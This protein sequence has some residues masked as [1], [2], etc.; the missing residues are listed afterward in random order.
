MIE[1][2][3]RELKY[4]GT[5][6]WPV[7]AVGDFWDSV[8]DYDCQ[9]ERVPAHKRRFADSLPYLDL[10][11]ENRVLDFCC[12]TGDAEVF[13]SRYRDIGN[14]VMADVSREFLK[15]SNQRVKPLVKNLETW[16]VDTYRLDLPD[17]SFDQVWCFETIEHFS[18]YAKVISETSR[19]LKKGKQ[20]V[21]TTPNIAWEA[22]HSIAAVLGIHHSEGPHKFL[23]R[24][25][26]I[27]A[28]TAAGLK[29]EKELTTVLW[30]CGP[31]W[32]ADFFEK[33]ERHLPM[34]IM[35]TIGLRR[36]FICRK[37]G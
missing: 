1:R 12:R 16:H 9:N 18:D 25:K 33:I 15:R 21:F 7:K 28:I 32:L 22:V 34:V 8:V 24:K 36:I 14:L 23:G 6:S 37:T 30:P 31:K 5:T 27:D 13:F 17:C 3:R 29:V 4:L 11:T 2:L 10:K 19:V 20:V 26:I 35:R